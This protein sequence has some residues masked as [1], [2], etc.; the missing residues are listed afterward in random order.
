MSKLEIIP[1]RSG[2]TFSTAPL[3]LSDLQG[4]AKRGWP[5][6]IG[7][8]A[9]GVAA[10]ALLLSLMPVTYKANVRMVLEQSVNDYLQSNKVTDG[11]TLG[12]DRYSQIHIISSEGVVMPVIEKLGL[13]QDPEFGCATEEKKSE[14]VVSTI[15]SPLKAVAGSIKSLMG[16]KAAASGATKCGESAIFKSVTDRLSV[17]W[18]AQPLVID[19]NFESKDPL[20]ASTI[21]NRISESYISS[22][23]ESKRSASKLAANAM[24]ERLTELRAQAA[25]AERKVLEYKLANNLANADPTALPAGEMTGLSDQI[26]SARL[27]V[28]DA[29][30]RMEGAQRTESVANDT[31]YIL[32]SDL[33]T[34]LRNQYLDTQ[35]SAKEMESRVGKKHAATIKLR[36]RMT[37]IAATIEAERKRISSSYVGQYEAA[38]AKYKELTSTITQ[39]FD[40]KAADGKLNAKLRDLEETAEKIRNSYSTM[41]ERVS[42]A[43]RLENNPLVLPYARILTHASVPTQPESSKKRLLVLLGSSMLGLLLGAG[44]AFARNNPLGVYR[45][46]DQVKTSLGL[47]T[48]VVPKIDDKSTNKL[49]EY[50]LDKPHS[51]FAESLRLL[52]SLISVARRDNHAKV[53]CVVTSLAGEGKTTIASNLANQIAKHAGIRTLLIDADFHQRSLTKSL[54]P[55]A[56]RGL[57]EALERPEQ[58]ADYVVALDRSGLDVL[59]CPL[60]HRI[61]NAAQLLGS[62]KMQALIRSARSS[63]D[64]IIIEPP[65]IAM[66]ADFRL[67]APFCDGFVFVIEWGKTSQRL[68]LEAVAEVHDFWERVL[69]IVLNKADA[70]ALQSIERYKGSNYQSYFTDGTEDTEFLAESPTPD[71]ATETK[72]IP[73]VK[74]VAI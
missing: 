48:L 41:L 30:F 15:L 29:K 19:V 1:S 54:T 43:N 24:Q 31:S 50:S 35:T 26:A 51:R 23:L 11:P 73:A 4:I 71:K 16:N 57:R 68:V 6:V 17:A 39:V 46:A 56:K 62:S 38:L 21:A 37:Q 2:P 66:L 58:F 10:G 65:P 70:T 8:I 18:E 64:L 52:W 60:E 3:D 44:A 33:V 40:E 5:Y 47:M 55:G 9:L 7:G 67:L 14:G 12:D 59:P 27:A 13:A 42:E 72:V 63:Y 69:C 25:D 36:K 53:I 61:P 74:T 34:R 45:T 20:K 22:T 28:L 32:D 49:T